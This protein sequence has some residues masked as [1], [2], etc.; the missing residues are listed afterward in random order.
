MDPRL[1]PRR[2]L[3][4][5]TSPVRKTIDRVVTMTKETWVIIGTMVMIGAIIVT[6]GAVGISQL[7]TRI[8]DVRT[9]VNGQLDDLDG[10]V[11]NLHGDV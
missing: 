8:D 1:T 11:E 9:D 7:A 10:D 2:Q 6:L 3:A 5:P 4:R